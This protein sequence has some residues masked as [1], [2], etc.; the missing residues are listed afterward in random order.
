MRDRPIFGSNSQWR[1]RHVCLSRAQ[2]NSTRI[3]SRPL[4][5]CL[6]ASALVVIVR[7][8]SDPGGA[9]FLARD[10]GHRRNSSDARRLR[11]DHRQ[12]RPA[13]LL[14]PVREGCDAAPGE[15][16][17]RASCL[18]LTHVRTLD[19]RSSHPARRFAL[20]E[21]GDGRNGHG[22]SRSG[23]TSCQFRFNFRAASR[24]RRSPRRCF[25]SPI[26]TSWWR[27][28][29]LA[30][31]ARSRRSI[32]AQVQTTRHGSWKSASGSTASSAKPAAHLPRSA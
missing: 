9:G 7:V 26:P 21:D 10:A 2:S 11:G 13:R 22:P 1:D 23:S 32:A 6:L 4:S 16:R 3:E 5:A 24:S 25:S 18:P 15:R 30:S 14:R 28:A 27:L 19:G 20:D 12:C 17:K 8:S 29:A 31:S